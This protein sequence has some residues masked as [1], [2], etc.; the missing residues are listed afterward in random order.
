[1]QSTLS[2]TYAETLGWIRDTKALGRSIITDATSSIED[3]G[4]FSQSPRTRDP[5]REQQKLDF[6]NENSGPVKLPQKGLGR[7]ITEKWNALAKKKGWDAQLTDESAGGIKGKVMLHLMELHD[8][9]YLGDAHKHL[10]NESIMGKFSKFM[11]DNVSPQGLIDKQLPKLTNGAITPHQSKFTGGERVG[12]TLPLTL[13][14][15]STE[16]IGGIYGSAF[17]K[18]K[19]R[20]QVLGIR[21]DAGRQMYK[22][23][24]E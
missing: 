12:G 14:E 10:G 24:T 20:L 3:I 23:G 1:M 4:K 2:E 13:S 16:V 17:A 11:Y 7:A 9:F 15:T 6:L 22:R 21:D 19:A 5:L 18:A 8:Q